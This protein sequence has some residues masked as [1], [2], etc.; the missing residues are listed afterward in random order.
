MARFGRHAQNPEP[1]RMQKETM[2]AGGKGVIRV[3]EAT[4]AKLLLVKAETGKALVTIADEMIAYGY[5]HLEIVD[6][7]E[8]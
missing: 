8:A 4:Y 7:E 2:T 1:L 3:S 5:D 6:E